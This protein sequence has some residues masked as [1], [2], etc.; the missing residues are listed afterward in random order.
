MTCFL[1]EKQVSVSSAS[2][3]LGHF[4]VTPQGIKRE[5][6][7][8]IKQKKITIP[9]LH[10]NNCSESNYSICNQRESGCLTGL[11]GLN[12][13]SPEPKQVHCS[14]RGHNM[15]CSNVR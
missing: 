6:Q 14:E 11:N 9:Y 2:Q 15:L 3:S 7:E 10:H 8:E 12:P 4:A 13:L 5:K 1:P